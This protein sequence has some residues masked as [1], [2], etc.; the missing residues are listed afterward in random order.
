MSTKE[1]REYHH[2][3]WTLA[4]LRVAVTEVADWADDAVVLLSAP[5]PRANRGRIEIVRDAT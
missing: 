5:E 2:I 4:D 1:I 3:G